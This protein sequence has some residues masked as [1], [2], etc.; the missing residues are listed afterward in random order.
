V[1]H[2]G[3]SKIGDKSSCASKEWDVLVTSDRAADAH[4]AGAYSPAEEQFTDSRDAC[5][6]ALRWREVKPAPF[7]YVKPRS[8]EEACRALHELGEDA[9]V[10]AGGQSL[11][12]M[13]NFRLARPSAL[14]DLGGVPGLDGIQFDGASVEIGAMVRHRRLERGGDVP[15]PLGQLLSA[16]G[17]HVGHLPIRTRGTFGGSVVHADPAAEWCVLV[18]L[19]DGEVIVESS[20]RTRALRADSFFVTI[21]TTT[22]EPDEVVTAVRLPLLGDS[23]RVGFCEFSRRAG[24]FAIVM[25]MAAVHLDGDV[26]AR[27]RLALGGV[28]DT[29]VRPTEA[30]AVLV[31]ATPGHDVFEDAGA[32]AAGEV[33]PHDDVH[34]SGEYR[35][36]LVRVMVRRSL[37]QAMRSPTD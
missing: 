4:R 14:V 35:R 3:Q 29:V 36:D 37:E 16:A 20:S 22:V 13:M 17:R 9:K 27:A 10:L 15:G 25:A 18:R 12:P 19:L 2:A 24:D 34:G 11:V 26:I 23:D 32:V 1:D 33:N 7:D 6:R 31:G 8:L 28:G 30:E 5:P 21:F